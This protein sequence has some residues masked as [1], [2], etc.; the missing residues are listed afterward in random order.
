MPRKA[1]AC[2]GTAA[3][4]EGV[5]QRNLGSHSLRIGGATALLHAGVDFATLSQWLGHTNL[6]TTMVYAR[7]DLDLKRQALAQVF[8]EVLPTPSIGHLAIPSGD[9]VDWLK[10]L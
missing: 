8:P 7:V 6:N 4:A 10:R 5:D 3:L 9:L 1:V 2:L